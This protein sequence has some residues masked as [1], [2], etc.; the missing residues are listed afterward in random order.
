[1]EDIFTIDNNLKII[2]QQKKDKLKTRDIL[3]LLEKYIQKLL[4]IKMTKRFVL[5]EINEQLNLN[6]NE[7]TFASFLRRKGHTTTTKKP[8]PQK[9][10]EVKK[11]RI[12]I[13]SDIP[14]I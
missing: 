10:E 6:I 11:E 7:N 5:S 9:K 3:N 12:N 8:Q 1:M 13:M 2:I 14:I 4:D